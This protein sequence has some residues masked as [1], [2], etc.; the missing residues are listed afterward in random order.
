MKSGASET[1]RRGEVI[2]DL[3]TYCDAMMTC[4]MCRLIFGTSPGMSDCRADSDKVRDIAK[5]I[6]NEH[7]NRR[8]SKK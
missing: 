6:V 2:R 3:S 7:Q 4:E 8:V 5:Y 1:K